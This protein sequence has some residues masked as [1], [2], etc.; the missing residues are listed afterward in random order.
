MVKEWQ[1]SNVGEV[2]TKKQ[3]P[4]VFRKTWYRVATLENA[5]HGFRRSGLYPLSPDGIDKSK[6]GPS[7]MTIRE[8]TPSVP[9]TVTQP[10]V[11]YSATPSVPVTAAQ[12][13]VSHSSVI[14]VNLDVIEAPEVVVSQST[15]VQVEAIPQLASPELATTG[16]LSPN[17]ISGAES[18]EQQ[19]S[20]DTSFSDPQ[21]SSPPMPLLPIDTNVKPQEAG[22]Y[23]KTLLT[24]RSDHS[25]VS[26]AFVNLSVPQPKVRKQRDTLPGKLPKALSGAEAIN[27]LHEKKKQKEEEE[28]AKQARKRTEKMFK[29]K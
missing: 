16:N 7:Q 19:A 4:A 12:P 15:G 17:N 2:L 21:S 5:A 8:A 1:M 6:L 23:V 18:I 27:L 24:F 11:S 13:S 26:P 25:Y 3:F 14:A 20:P 29:T 10:S 9:V 28:I 22:S